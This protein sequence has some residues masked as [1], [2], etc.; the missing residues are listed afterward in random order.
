MRPVQQSNNSGVKYDIITG[1]RGKFWYWGQ[2][3]GLQI[4]AS[5]IIS[6]HNQVVGVCLEPRLDV[7]SLRFEA[8]LASPDFVP[9]TS[10]KKGD[11]MF[12]IIA[13]D[14]ETS[15]NDFLVWKSFDTPIWPERSKGSSAEGFT[16]FRWCVSGHL[17]SHFLVRIRVHLCEIA[18]S[19]SERFC[20]P[21]CRRGHQEK[22]LTKVFSLS[23][24]KDTKRSLLTL[25][26]HWKA[27]ATSS[28][29]C[30]WL[31]WVN[32][33]K[34]GRPMP[35][36]ICQAIDIA[37]KW[38][39]V[40]FNPCSQSSQWSGCRERSLK[41]IPNTMKYSY[42]II[43]IIDSCG[44]EGHVSHLPFHD[45]RLTSARPCERCHRPRGINEEMKRFGQS[46]NTSC[47]WF[48]CDAGVGQ[49][50]M[51]TLKRCF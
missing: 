13:K 37:N 35:L 26:H 11:I 22:K 16:C 39:F 19:R 8:W 18:D 10:S 4:I 36:V 9:G 30:H 49:V 33:K 24:L 1:E 47:V 25:F 50:A 48:H 34:Q 6:L 28:S 42:D 14:I 3:Q 21:I 29:Q 32:W 40:A 44:K 23:A 43:D 20:N 12:Q 41:W 17:S 38:M 46:R 2:R 15:Q 31:H 7:I 45:L 51:W 5:Q 27:A